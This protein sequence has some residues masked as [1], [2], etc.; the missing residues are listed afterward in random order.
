MPKIL[1]VILKVAL[2]VAV[3]ARKTRL[4][5]GKGV[6]EV[7]EGVKI[8]VGELEKPGAAPRAPSPPGS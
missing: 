8:L 1:R 3:I 2:G 5:K 4:L 6:D 7:I